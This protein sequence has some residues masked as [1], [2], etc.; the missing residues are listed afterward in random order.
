[1]PP[2]HRGGLD[3][4]DGIRPAGPQA[5]QQDP[6]QAVGGSQPWTRR[7]ALENDQLVPQREILEHQK[8]LGPGPAEE[9]C[10]NEGDHVGHHRSGRPKVNVDETDGVNRR[11]RVA[12]MLGH[13]TTQMVI[14]HYHKYVPNLTRRDGDALAR[15]LGKRRRPR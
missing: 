8:A 10:E 7:G 9:P 1:M 11:H 6:E 15:A 5:G 14:R 4:G 12:K 13:R 2:D 3:D